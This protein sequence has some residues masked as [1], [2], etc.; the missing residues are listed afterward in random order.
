MGPEVLVPI[1][2]VVG[3][4]PHPAIGDRLPNQTER[5]LAVD[6]VL[7]DMDSIVS[8]LRKKRTLYSKT[9]PV[10]MRVSILEKSYAHRERPDMWTGPFP[11]VRVE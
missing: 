8:E 1:L 10:A 9:P 6:S 7:C 4:V 3:P 11:V 2:L 5:M